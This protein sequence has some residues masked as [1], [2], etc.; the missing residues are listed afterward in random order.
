[1]SIY[2][3]IRPDTSCLIIGYTQVSRCGGGSA[4]TVHE[5]QLFELQQRLRRDRVWTLWGRL[6][7]ERVLSAILSSLQVCGGDGRM[8]WRAH[9]G[10]DARR[11]IP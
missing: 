7:Q 10:S 5:L 1:M 2:T 11:V 9:E 8:Q 6:F 4:R 3:G